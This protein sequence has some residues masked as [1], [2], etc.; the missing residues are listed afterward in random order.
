MNIENGPENF[1][2]ISPNSENQSPGSK[3][4]L[5]NPENQTTSSENLLLSSEIKLSPE[6][7]SA[8]IKIAA[9]IKRTEGFDSDYSRKLAS[10]FLQA[11]ESRK[12]MISQAQEIKGQ[13][14][15]PDEIG[16]NRALRYFNLVI[17]Q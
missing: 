17:N 8:V 13:K 9:E 5:S 6:Q 11:E 16:N 14:F 2:P 15:S 1:D 10:F 12:R 4:R 7:I 3:T